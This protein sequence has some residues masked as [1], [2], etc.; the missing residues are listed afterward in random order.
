MSGITR[1]WVLKRSLAVGI[2]N[3]GPPEGAQSAS[4]EILLAERAA[5][6]CIA[7]VV[8]SSTRL[9]CELTRRTRRI[10]PLGRGGQLNGVPPPCAKK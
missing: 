3:V 7:G 9:A 1:R 6:A 2:A 4:E 10:S 5:M 8:Q